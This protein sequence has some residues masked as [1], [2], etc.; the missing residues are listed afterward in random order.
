MTA[1]PMSTTT[2]PPVPPALAHAAWILAGRIVAGWRSQPAALVIGWLFPILITCMFLGLFGGALKVPGDGPYLD[3]LIPG[4][5]AVTMLFGL[6]NTTLA[7]AADAARGVNDRLRSLPVSAAAIVLGRALADMLNSLIG[8][9]VMIAF[10]VA[11]GWRPALTPADALLALGMLLWL[12]FA[13]LWVGISIGYR[14]RSV[15][16]VA[17]VQI[18]VWPVA[19]LSSVFVDPAT[20]PTWLAAIVEANPVSATATT[21]RDLLGAVTWKGNIVPAGVSAALALAWP[22]GLAA[23]F[24]PLAARSFREAR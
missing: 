15:D 13:L 11:M 18:L 24:L 17:Y 9:A 1:M 2:A 22:T 16:S 3:F 19:L 8:L 12:R 21:V 20:M 14:A 7:A 5:L 6:E 4:M 23:I 10:G